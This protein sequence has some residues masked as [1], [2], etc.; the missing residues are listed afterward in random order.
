MLSELAAITEAEWLAQC[1][2]ASVAGADVLRAERKG[3]KA[4][5]LLNSCIPD[6]ALVTAW[7]KDYEVKK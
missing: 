7:A 3:N 2:P 6:P 1:P 5:E 4:R